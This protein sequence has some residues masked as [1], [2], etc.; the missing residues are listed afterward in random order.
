MPILRLTNQ[1]I[2]SV[3]FPDSGQV[4]YWDDASSKYGLRGFGLRV[5]K[6]CKT[7]V[8]QG[9]VSGRDCRV[10]I[11]TWPVL[12]SEEAMKRAKEVLAQM[13]AGVNPNQKKAHARQTSSNSKT[14]QDLYDD[15]MTVKTVRQT[16][17]KAYEAAY[18]LCLS[19]WSKKPLESITYEMTIK[20]YRDISEGMRCYEGKFT[21]PPASKKRG[22]G[23]SLA[24]MAVKL[25]GQLFHFE[26]V[27]YE[28]SVPNPISKLSML[29]KGWNESKQRQT[30]I[31]DHD[32]PLV[33]KHLSEMKKDPKTQ[34]IVDYVMLLILTGL[35]KKEAAG[36]MWSEVNLR[37][38]YIHIPGS[39]TK[40]G[41]A[42][43]LPLP[44]YLLSLF[45]RRY[46]ENAGKSNF[47]FPTVGGMPKV[48]H[49][50]DP[51]RVFEE[52]SELLGRSADTGDHITPHVL[53]HTFATVCMNIRIHARV[54]KMLLNHSQKSDVT[55]RYIHSN[56]DVLREPMAE[57]N[58]HI[59][60]LMGVDQS[61]EPTNIKPLQQKL[62]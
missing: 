49:L 60:N 13:S 38:A 43:A 52:L 31:F 51:A 46:I 61:V 19:D 53:R 34:T 12:N 58:S 29:N 55:W 25:L 1:N 40:N 10:K 44:P 24:I 57:V 42:H 62:S 26:N 3:P 32:F 5:S 27:M 41:L 28:T 36:L 14:L 9:T 17:N 18:R 47:V 8:A 54:Q 21:I 35:R 59:L 45:L 48:K 2:E 37:E 22:P 4:I 16:S 39:R 23:K 30:I 20:R 11:G 15:Y 33:Y 50:C 56:I 7:F 6:G